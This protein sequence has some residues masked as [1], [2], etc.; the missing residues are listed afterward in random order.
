VDFTLDETQRSVAEL[1]RTVLPAVPDH[2]R[3][4][5]AL[6][7]DPGFDETAW[8]GLSQAGLLSVAVPVALGGDG[9]GAL[10]VA[11]LLEVVGR[12]TLPLPALAT[13]SLGVLPLAALGGAEVLRAVADGAVLTGALT[14]MAWSDGTVTGRATAVP[15]AAQAMRIVVPCADGLALVRPADATL[16]R[17]PTSSGAPEYTVRC[18]HAPAELVAGDPAVLDRFAVAGAVAV[19]DGVLAGALALTAE[20]ARTR[21]QFGKPLATFQAVAQQLADLYVAARTVH[22]ASCAANYTHGFDDLDI[23]AY[24][25][26]AE[27]PAALQTCHHLHGGL[28]LDVTYPLHRYYAQAKDLARLLGGASARLDRIGARC[29]SN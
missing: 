28:G 15:Y 13:L 24:W 4:E 12:Q 3:T 17:T 5:Q 8:K 18:E 23:A 16:A 19:A 11:A 26:A 1:T 2:A 29:S 27:L 6:A 9:L 21:H 25:V 14:P 20:H 22:L 10:E 7:S